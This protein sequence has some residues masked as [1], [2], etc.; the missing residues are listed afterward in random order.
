[1]FKRLREW[2]TTPRDFE[3]SKPDI[4]EQLMSSDPYSL[5]PNQRRIYDEISNLRLDKRLLQKM[6]QELHAA[7]IFDSKALKAKECELRLE[8]LYENDAA[9]RKTADEGG[10]VFECIMDTIAVL[11]AELSATMNRDNPKQESEKSNG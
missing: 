7:D 2:W 10:T 3:T 5:S 6:L 1:M 4:I 11:K 8:Y 9:F